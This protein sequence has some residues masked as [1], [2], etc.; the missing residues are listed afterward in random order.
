MSADVIARKTGE[1]SDST[2]NTAKTLYAGSSKIN[3]PFALAIGANILWGM[4]FLA[5]KYTLAVWTPIVATEIRFG[6]AL[7]L[8]AIFF[9]L[10]GFK[11]SIPR[12]KEEWLG[13]AL[14]GFFGF[15]ILYPTQL[16]GL[17][18]IPSGLSASLMLTSPL[19]VLIFAYAF[20]DERLSST[21]VIAVLA[22]I[23]GGLILLNPS[24]TLSSPSM[25]QNSILHGSLLTLVASLSLAA[26][27]VSTRAFSRTMNAQSLTF[28]SALIGCVVLIPFGLGDVQPASTSQQFHQA[29]TAS[30][31]L[32]A[33]CSAICFLMWNKSISLLP[34]KQVA[35]AMH[36]KTP[37]AILVGIL[38][39]GEPLSPTTIGGSVVVAC[40]VWLSQLGK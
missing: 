36:V 38:T 29:A 32:A 23:V 34:A 37:V 16:K 14:V 27:V 1:T 2:T 6:L 12:G 26:S 17:T 15:G 4:S 11:I 33:I 30:V 31:F 18:E 19:F 35:S 40:G 5:S 7:I 20:L 10:A 8:M 13:V 9:P 28:W 22:G 39:I 3:S 24:K 25:S 21:K